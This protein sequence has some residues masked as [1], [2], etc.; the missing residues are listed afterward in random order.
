[1]KLNKK[2]T[3]RGL[4]KDRRDFTKQV[5]VA[6]F[7][8]LAGGSLLTQLSCSATRKLG[9]GEM[10]KKPLRGVLKDLLKDRIAIDD[11]T[12]FKNGGLIWDKARLGLYYD[13]DDELINIV[14]YETAASAVVSENNGTRYLPDDVWRNLIARVGPTTTADDAVD[15]MVDAVIRA[16]PL[17]PGNEGPFPKGPLTK[18]TLRAARKPKNG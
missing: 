17:P 4:R 16:V 10:A 11:P 7:S 9:E 8:A 5:V 15:P 3:P 12:N 13:D 14:V 1:M 2:D 18:P 6:G